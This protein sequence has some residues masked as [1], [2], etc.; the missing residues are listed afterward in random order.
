MYFDS[1]SP[2]DTVIS[3]N[4][5]AYINFRI[6]FNVL[7]EVYSSLELEDSGLF[8]A[9]LSIGSLC[10]QPWSICCLLAHKNLYGDS[11]IFA[12][13]GDSDDTSS[14]GGPLR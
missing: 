13:E 1:V 9:A 4:Q 3:W 5:E 7:R 6:V 10:D 8:N 14:R 11:A 2:E 12:D